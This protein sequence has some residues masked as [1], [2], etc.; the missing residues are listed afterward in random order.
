MW[1]ICYSYCEL[2]ILDLQVMCRACCL[3]ICQVL[4]G[5]EVLGRA[6]DEWTIMNRNSHDMA[7][8]INLTREDEDD[9]V[10]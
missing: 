10:D 5:Q 4:R 7:L 3:L 2:K 6:V 1:H 8:S 9:V